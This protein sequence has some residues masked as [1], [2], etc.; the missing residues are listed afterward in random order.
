MYKLG[1]WRAEDLGRA[2]TIF[3]TTRPYAY[4]LLRVAPP[5]Q[6]EDIRRFETVVPTV[7]LSSGIFRT[8]YPSRF[9]DVDAVVAETLQNVFPKDI[10]LRIH[11]WA[12]SDA[13]LSMRWAEKTLA[14]YPRATFTAS[15]LILYLIE[16]KGNR[17]EEIFVLEPDGTPLQYI[18]PP[19]V[20]SL[21]GRERSIYPMNV[22]VSAWGR[23][24]AQTLNPYAAGLSW[25]SFTDLAP[26]RR[27]PW[28]FRLI[29]LLHPSAIQFAQNGRFHILQWDALARW[30]EPVQVIRCLNLYHPQIFG[31]ER[32]RQ[33]V[34]A[35]L[36]SLSEGGLFVAGRTLEKEG[37]RNDVS[38]FRKAGGRAAVLART[39]KGFQFEDW[40]RDYHY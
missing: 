14:A 40:A 26:I 33:S 24:R 9:E 31:P 1:I 16:A 6:A 13:F 7:E 25:T 18:R 29:P 22:L 17:P 15:D 39:G 10:P 2:R 5:V 27:G 20:V 3:G 38:I 34:T 19:F 12:A 8:T 35:A 28:T 30:P 37:R 21:Q 11:D 32:I 36:E 23:R 4:T